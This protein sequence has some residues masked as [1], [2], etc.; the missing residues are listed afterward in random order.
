[1]IMSKKSIMLWLGIVVGIIGFVY[2][3]VWLDKAMTKT[4]QFSISGKI[5][6][7]EIAGVVEISAN[8]IIK[9]ED[10]E[11]I[12]IPFKMDGIDHT[13]TITI[14]EKDDKSGSMTVT[15]DHESLLDIKADKIK[16]D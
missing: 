2:G 1:M 10:G 12:T 13:I 7:R 15:L 3:M 9:N 8:G 4:E 6:D 5:G 16:T 14:I 11:S